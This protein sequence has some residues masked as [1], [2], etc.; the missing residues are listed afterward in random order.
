M[1]IDKEMQYKI[2]GL[3]SDM[4]RFIRKKELGYFFYTA[5]VK[6]RLKGFVETEAEAELFRIENILLKAILEVVFMKKEEEYE[7]TKFIGD[8]QRKIKVSDEIK[9]K[10]ETDDNFKAKF[11]LSFP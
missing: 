9:I 11:E 6:D 5:E 8:V 2:K 10:Y 1:N 3:S 4:S 7:C